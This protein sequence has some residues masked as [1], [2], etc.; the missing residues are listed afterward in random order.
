MCLS[1]DTKIVSRNGI[2]PIRNLIGN[3]ALLVPRIGHLGGL[4]VRG[5][6]KQAEVRS[7]GIQQLWEITLQRA[8]SIRTVHAT[9]NQRWFITTERWQ[10]LQVHERTTQRLHVGDL[11]R[12]LHANASIKEQCLM[13]V[14]AAQGFVFGDGSCGVGERP[15]FVNLNGIK[16]Q[17]L[18]PFFAGYQPRKVM[19]HSERNGKEVEK[20]AALQIY[21]LPRFWKQLPPIQESR[22]FLLSWLAGYFA[23]D[24]SVSESSATLGSASQESLNFAR[25]VLAVCGIGYTVIRR[26]MRLGKG[27]ELSALYS[28]GLRISDLPSW[29]FLLP[30]HLK[31]IKANKHVKAGPWRVKKV[32]RLEK[33][34]DVFCA[35]SM[36]VNAF[37]LSEDLACGGA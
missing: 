24:G 34:E 11:L 27:K 12:T 28:I 33:H 31:R 29:F 32:H 8:K 2:L 37:G 19:V 21:G 14:A 17:A 30:H 25:D 4:S 15:S 22:A 18:L 6:F 3:Q 1:G 13:P 23:A 10:K 7:F 35:Q 20:K 26:Q 5:T 36:N 9:A 16:D